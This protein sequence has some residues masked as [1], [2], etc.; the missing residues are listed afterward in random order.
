[1]DEH[2]EMWIEARKNGVGGVPAT[3]TLV[4]DAEEID[5]ELEQLAI[6]LAEAKVIGDR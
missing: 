3:R 2:I 1:M 5:A 6:V 4:R